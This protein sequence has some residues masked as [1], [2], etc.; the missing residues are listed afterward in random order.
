MKNPT[1]TTDSP[2]GEETAALWAI[3]DRLDRVL[4]AVMALAR[5]LS[6]LSVEL[7]RSRR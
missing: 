1:A 5:N 7:D 3:A 2:A 6:D 4:D